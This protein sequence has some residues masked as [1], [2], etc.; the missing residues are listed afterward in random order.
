MHRLGPITWVLLLSLGAIVSGQAAQEKEGDLK[1]L[2]GRWV[3]VSAEEAGKEMEGLAGGKLIIDGDMLTLKAPNKTEAKA[4]IRL[5]PAKKPKQID[6][7][8]SKD[9][10]LLG[11]YSLEGDT[12]RLCI[13]PATMDKRPAEF[14]TK[15]DNSHR[16]IVFKRVK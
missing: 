5:D 7:E 16:L 3:V 9:E 10:I 8:M 11:I 1:R 13:D 4:R 15:K 6:L 12:L 14:A 2:A